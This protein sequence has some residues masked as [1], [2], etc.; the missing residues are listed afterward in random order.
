MSADFVFAVA[1]IDRTQDDWQSFVTG[2]DDD[3]LRQFITATNYDFY[4]D[5][6]FEDSVN[7]E[8]QVRERLC[9]AIAVCFGG[10]REIGYWRDNGREFVVT[11][12]MSWGD[13]PTDAMTDVFML[14]VLRD[15]RV[16]LE[17]TA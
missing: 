12:G 2:M 3:T 13:E 9:E 6:F 7:I 11:G 1:E 4:W 15:W 16:S 5:E 14:S 8:R 17:A 10:S